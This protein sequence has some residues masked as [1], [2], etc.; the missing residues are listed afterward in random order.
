MADNP[1]LLPLYT[2]EDCVAAGG[3]VAMS[4]ARH[5]AISDELPITNL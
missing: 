1:D 2:Y 5:A 4:K 3:V